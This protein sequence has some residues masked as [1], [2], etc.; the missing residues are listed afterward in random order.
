MHGGH[1][2]QVQQA[3]KARLIAMVEPVLA[4]F[5]EIVAIWRGTRCES[6]GKPTGDPVPVIRVG[7]LVLDRAGLGP[8][9]TMEMVAP[10]NPYA[11]LSEDELIERLE[12]LLDSAKAARDRHRA[13]LPEA[14]DTLLIEDFAEL[15]EEDD[16]PLEPVHISDVPFP[17][18]TDTPEERKEDK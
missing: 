13:Q 2:P 4:A 18:G 12:T 7:Q 3:A 9:A 8:H 5:E 6:C 11:D 16:E 14:M 1:A 15:P 10:S 17:D